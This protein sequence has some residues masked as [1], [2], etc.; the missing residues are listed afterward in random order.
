M[1]ELKKIEFNTLRTTSYLRLV[2]TSKQITIGKKTLARFGLT[3]D[4]LFEGAFDENNNPFLV[5]KKKASDHTQK[6]SIHKNNGWGYLSNAKWNLGLN[7][8]P[9]INYQLEKVTIKGEVCLKLTEI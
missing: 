1:T 3:S 9:G 7:L 4:T 5:I 6:L 8:T 2:P